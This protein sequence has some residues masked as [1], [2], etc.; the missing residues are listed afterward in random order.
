MKD[1]FKF[2]GLLRISELYL[3]FGMHIFWSKICSVKTLR[4]RFC[5]YVWQNVT[6]KYTNVCKNAFRRTWESK[7]QEGYL[8]NSLEFGVWKKKRNLL[9]LDFVHL[10]V[11]KGKMV[12]SLK[13]PVSTL[14][15]EIMQY[16]KS[17]WCV[18]SQI[19]Y[20]NAINKVKYWKLI[21]SRF[22]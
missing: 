9:S 6:S 22:W 12:K 14:N 8:T 3:N 20:F 17:F 7:E 10:F 11:T 2:C 16:D 15:W 13:L 1:F 18:N 19:I 4:N 21:W 5:F